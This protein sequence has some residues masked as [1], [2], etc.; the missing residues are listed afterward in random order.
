[1]ATRKA[2]RKKVYRVL[3]HNE[4]RLFEVY[5][6]NVSQGGLFGFVEIEGFL[7]GQKSSVVVDPSEDALKHEL[8]GVERSYVPMH[9]V[10][11]IDEVEQRGPARIHST[12]ERGKVTPLP[13]PIYTPL[14][15]E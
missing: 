13:G 2:A 6:R 1:M 14:K 4:G 7:F 5:A 9:A 12:G 8:E 10:V 11:R 15:K 3:F